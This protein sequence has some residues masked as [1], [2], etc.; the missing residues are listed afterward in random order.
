[1]LMDGSEKSAREIVEE[2]DWFRISD[3]AVITKICSNV[4]NDSS[5]FVSILA[6][7]SPMLD[8]PGESKSHYGK[9]LPVIMT[10]NKNVPNY[11]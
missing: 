5:K 7:T 4:V 10:Q 3:E 9:E 11:N 8:A 6:L 2:K 1:M